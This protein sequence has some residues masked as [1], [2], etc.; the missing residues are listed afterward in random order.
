MRNGK[1]YGLRSVTYGFYMSLMVMMMSNDD[2]LKPTKRFTKLSYKI[3]DYEVSP[4]AKLL[5]ILLL[6]FYQFNKDGIH[7]SQDYMAKKMRISKR[8]IRRLLTELR[9]W[10]LIEWEQVEKKKG[11][12]NH[13]Y[14]DDEN[15]KRLWRK[16]GTMK[17]SKQFMKKREEKTQ[18]K[19]VV[20]NE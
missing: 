8:H 7:P 3:F 5:Y 12:C 16:K 11:V 15:L 9:A 2:I 19:M 18:L 6:G 1:P 17:L 10:L 4:Q 20:N 14:L 13:Y